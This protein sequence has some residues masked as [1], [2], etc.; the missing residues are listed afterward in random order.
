VNK[1]AG[2]S[3]G[4]QRPLLFPVRLSACLFFSTFPSSLAFKSINGIELANPEEDYQDNA[5]RKM[6][7]VRAGRIDFSASYPKPVR[8]RK[9][10]SMSLH[11]IYQ[12]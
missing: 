10:K 8:L 12:L 3:H 2:P 7:E 1:T 4:D 9:E 11:N 5:G 6:V